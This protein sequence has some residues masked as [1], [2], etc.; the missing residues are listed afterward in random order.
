MCVCVVVG[1]SIYIYINCFMNSTDNQTREE[2]YMRRE[3]R[4][5][6]DVYTS[7]EAKR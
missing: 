6:T 1:G 3:E 5:R 2:R 4:G 7:Y